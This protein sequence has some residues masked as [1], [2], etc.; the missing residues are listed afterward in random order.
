M[1]LYF[2]SMNLYCVYPE[3][4]NSI[5]QLPNCLKKSETVVV[6][7]VFDDV[8]YEVVPRE[9]GELYLDQLPNITHIYPVNAICL[10]K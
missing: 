4:L 8:L 7:F 10:L 5:R 1:K 6:L 3:M 2:P 9:S